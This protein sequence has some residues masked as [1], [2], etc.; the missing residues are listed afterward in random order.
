MSLPE[1]SKHACASEPS[2][3][4]PYTWF[5]LDGDRGAFFAT[6]ADAIDEANNTYLDFTG[7]F[8]K[9]TVYVVQVIDVLGKP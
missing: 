8:A 9:R 4:S 1:K 2:Q 3:E 7:S 5:D 6:L